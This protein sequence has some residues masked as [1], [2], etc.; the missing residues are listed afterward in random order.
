[1]LSHPIQKKNVSNE[2]IL[3]EKERDKRTAFLGELQ[4]GAGVACLRTA[5]NAPLHGHLLVIDLRRGVE[6]EQTLTTRLPFV[7]PSTPISLVCRKERERDGVMYALPAL[8]KRVPS[9]VPDEVVHGPS[10][11]RVEPMVIE[12]E[13]VRTTADLL[14]IA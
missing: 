5:I 8:G 2:N 12:V 3:K 6:P 9:T 11:E 4:A 14:R 7:I 1:M 13:R 10:R